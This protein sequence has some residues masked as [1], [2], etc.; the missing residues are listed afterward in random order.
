ML[1]VG[2]GLFAWYQKFVPDADL[3]AKFGE[4]SN[5]VFPTWIVNE[6]PM[7]I[8]GLILAGA[9]AAAISS[10]DSILAALSQTS[11]SI[12]YGRNRMEREGEGAEMV[13]K[14]RVA[15][16]IW[17]VVLTLAGLVLWWIY[18][19]N[20]DSDLIGLAFGMVAYTYGPLL[21][22]LMAALLPWK[23]ST[24]GLIVGTVMIVLESIGMRGIA[25]S[26]MEMRPKLASEWFFPLNAAITYCCGWFGGFIAKKD[27]T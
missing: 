1:A 14:S 11:L 13:K 12:I 4:N 16:C 8:S 3:A 7:G 24:W 17:G 2:A 10:L 25:E 27:G 20:E 22:V 9:F 26:L 15:V 5:F 21:G 6:V 18:S 23:S 19:N